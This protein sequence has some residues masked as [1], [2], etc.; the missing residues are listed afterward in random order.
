MLAKLFTIC[1]VQACIERLTQEFTVKDITAIRKHRY[2]IK[3]FETGDVI[4]VKG[5]FV[6]RDNYYTVSAT[7]IKALDFDF[8]DM[9]A[10]G[11]NTFIISITN[12]TIKNVES[13][14]SLEFYVEEKVR[15]KE[16]SNFWVETRHNVNNKYL[17]NKTG[18]I[19]QNACS[20][21]AILVSTIMYDVSTGKHIV[22]LEDI[23]MITSNHNN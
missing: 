23:T 13:S 22:V 4:S 11:I 14:V 5:K 17:S 10:L 21:T 2:Y 20:T 18:A 15:E 8:D 16:P 1:Y 12:Q 9:P 19:N 7:S 3:P 6:G